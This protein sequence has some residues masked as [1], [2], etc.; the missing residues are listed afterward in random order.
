MSKL[1]V[2][3]APLKYNVKLFQI[4]FLLRTRDVPIVFLFRM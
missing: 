4:V 2:I 3:V 1:Q